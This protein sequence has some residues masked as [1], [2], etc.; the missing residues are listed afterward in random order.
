MSESLLT[1][2]VALWFL[3]ASK[4]ILAAYINPMSKTSKIISWILI[5]FS[6]FAAK[7]LLY[8]LH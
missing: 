5:F 6:F 3:A 4:T 2:A 8:L 7:L 1:I